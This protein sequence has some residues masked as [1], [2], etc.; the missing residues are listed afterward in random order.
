MGE[1]LS[2]TPMSFTVITNPRGRAVDDKDARILLGIHIEHS[3]DF[4][5]PFQD[6]HFS[7]P[8]TLSLL[9][10]FTSAL[11]A[12]SLAHEHGN[13]IPAH[14][15][16][17]LV[18]ATCS[19]SLIPRLAHS[20]HWGICSDVPFLVRVLLMNLRNLFTPT[21]ASLPHHSVLSPSEAHQHQKYS[22]PFISFLALDPKAHM[23]RNCICFTHN[24]IPH[25]PNSTWHSTDTV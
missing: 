4:P 10:I 15:L 22:C 21:D 12:F 24:Y 19:S 3:L 23:N 11:L 5:F 17:P 8:S 1:S 16:W 25:T 7:D 14:K 2:R 20:C 13:P 6:I 18:L 9:L